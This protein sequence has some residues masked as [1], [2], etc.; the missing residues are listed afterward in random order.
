MSSIIPLRITP[1]QQIDFTRP[2]RYNVKN[3]SKTSI[4]LTDSKWDE[5]VTIKIPFILKALSYLGL[6]TIEYKR[7]FDIEE[8]FL[9]KSNFI[10]TKKEDAVKQFNA[11]WQNEVISILNDNSY[12]N[13]MICDWNVKYTKTDFN[14]Y[15]N[16]YVLIIK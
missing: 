16:P 15:M 11:P 14:W 13:T 6:I 5:E 3:I 10:K 9:E 4:T 12:F 8:S 1:C 2:H 7:L